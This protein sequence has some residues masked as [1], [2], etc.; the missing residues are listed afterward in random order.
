MATS[1]ST[2]SD[3]ATLQSTHDTPDA[4]RP[5]LDAIARARAGA[6]D[7]DT[8]VIACAHRID[9]A[10]FAIDA[11]GCLHIGTSPQG[12]RGIRSQINLDQHDTLALLT[13]VQALLAA[14][15]HPAAA[16]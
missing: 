10:E 13:F 15:Q 3:H 11:N 8:E 7:P 1:T 2:Q 14:E 16:A 4:I 9:A 12:R 6:Y 5:A